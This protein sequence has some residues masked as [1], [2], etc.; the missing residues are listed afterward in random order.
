MVATRDLILY[1]RGFICS[2]NTLLGFV[3][4][5]AAVCVVFYDLRFPPCLF[6]PMPDRL[7]VQ[8]DGRKLAGL[9]DSS[10]QVEE[11]PEE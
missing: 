1:P 11:S 10:K 4:C 9:E 5:L 7:S 3:C 2:L 8:V 6:D